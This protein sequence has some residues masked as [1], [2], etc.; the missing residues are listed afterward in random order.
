MLAA[1]A[2]PDSVNNATNGLNFAKWRYGW[3]KLIVYELVIAKIFAI[4]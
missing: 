4:I 2:S 3:N 1:L